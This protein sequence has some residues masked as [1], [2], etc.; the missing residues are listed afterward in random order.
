[1]VLPVT[2]GRLEQLFGARVQ[3]L[4]PDVV[5][6]VT[7]AAL[8]QRLGATEE[9]SGFVRFPYIDRGSYG[10]RDLEGSELWPGALRAKLLAA[11]QEASGRSFA[12][13]GATAFTA[14]RALLL[15]PGDYVLDHHDPLGPPGAPAT[16]DAADAASAL[17]LMLDLSP[18]AVAEAEVI[19]RRA[20]KPC[21]QLPSQPGA[22]SI[23]E[24]D[25]SVSCHHGYVSKRFPGARVVRLVLRLAL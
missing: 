8:R 15:G 22:L 17:E 2:G 19:Y 21:F 18:A 23:V 16:G 14:A 13:G 1:M 12:G 3:K 25:G 5:D 20:G 11:A 6:A 24:R 9:A 10:W 4:V 7:A